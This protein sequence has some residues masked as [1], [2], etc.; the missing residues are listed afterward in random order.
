MLLLGFTSH[1]RHSTGSRGTGRMEPSATSQSASG[2]HHYGWDRDGHSATVKKKRSHL[3]PMSG[4]TPIA[5]SA[6]GGFS[7]EPQVLVLQVQQDMVDAHASATGASS[8]CQ[9]CSRTCRDWS[10]LVARS[11][12]TPLV[13]QTTGFHCDIRHGSSRLLPSR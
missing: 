1:C 11:R 8:T 4:A 9:C 12:S 5:N 10:P 3:V 6:T 13:E 7:R 2:V